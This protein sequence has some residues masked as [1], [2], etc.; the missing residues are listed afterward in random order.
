MDTQ[1]PPP[2]ELQISLEMRAEGDLP[3]GESNVRQSQET[4]EDSGLPILEPDGG[5]SHVPRNVGNTKL[6]AAKLEGHGLF[7]THQRNTGQ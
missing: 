6:Q 5:R 3:K 2:V 1:A 7:Q 4:Y